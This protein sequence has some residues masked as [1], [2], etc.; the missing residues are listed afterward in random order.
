VEKLFYGRPLDRAEQEMVSRLPR[1]TEQL[2]AHIPR[3]DAV[4]AM[5]EHQATP[6]NGGRQG[7]G[8][9]GDDL[10][11]GARILKVALD[12]D[13]LEASGIPPEQSLET[14]RARIG[15]YDPKVLHALGILR[16]LDAAEDV[17]CELP[18][19]S[20][21]SGMRF[22]EDIRTRTGVLLIPK[23]FE[24]NAALLERIRNI[25]P[26]AFDGPVKVF[27]KASSPWAHPAAA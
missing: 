7:S 12:F 10:P 16:G 2:L 15:A 14:M 4:R 27:T 8:P 21:Q 13:V 5:V 18:L 22:L 9:R 17:V 20:V 3:L 24:V 25:S 19:T 23:G 1:I 26:D 11:I 6:F